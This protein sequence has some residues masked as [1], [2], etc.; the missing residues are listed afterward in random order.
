MARAAKA[1]RAA[2][3]PDILEPGL[4]T[5]FCGSA[6]S[7]AS[8]KAGAYYARPGNRF[9]PALHEAGFTDRR[10]APGEF[11]A[12]TSYGIGLTDLAKHES[13]NDDA[14]SSSAYDADAL[15]ERIERC[16]PRHLAFTGK[17]PAGLFL[18]QIFGVALADY[19]PQK[20]TL[21]D[22]RIFV[23]PSPSGLASRW[24]SIEPW[25]ALA[26]L[27]RSARTSLSAE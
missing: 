20:P 10:L 3:L 4:V 18:L 2:V 19:G 17:R 27:H 13:G 16:R 22:T 1:S 24:W 8:A 21:G 6:A 7:S 9:W 5:V 26:D 12:V 11:R 15:R 23:L 14:L 25:R